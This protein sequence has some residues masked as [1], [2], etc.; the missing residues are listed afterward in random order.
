MYLLRFLC[1]SAVGIF[2]FSTTCLAQGV[3]ITFDDLP[4]N[5]NLP[6][7]LTRAEI[8]EG[9]L[10]VLKQHHVPQVFGFINSKKLERNPDGVAALKLWVAGGE[11]VGNHT[12]S[13]LDLHQNTAELFERDIAQ[14]EPVLALLSEKGD[15][16]WF[17]YP[18]LREGDTIEKRRAVRSYLRD[19]GYRIAQVTIDYEDYAWNTPYARC[20]DKPNERS[21]EWLNSSYLSIASAYIDANREMARLVFGHDVNHVL[22]LHLGA[23]TSTILPQVLDML[24]QKGL[25]LITLEAAETDPIYQVDPDAPSKFG[26]SL[27]EQWMDAKKLPYPKVPPKPLKDLTAVCQ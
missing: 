16:H 25:H 6:A 13:H 20:L 14:N 26:G 18:F 17:R 22:L 27:L 19:Q 21:I 1:W 15:W 3:A 4:L 12:Y 5:G 24:Q 10:G 9:V 8:V 11:R 7:G 23:F 2:L